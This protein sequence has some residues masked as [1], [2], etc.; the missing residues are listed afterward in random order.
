MIL[1]KDISGPSE[2]DVSIALNTD[3][4]TKKHKSK[5]LNISK[6]GKVKQMKMCNFVDGGYSTTSHHH[7]PSTAATFQQL[8]A[9]LDHYATNPVV[10][11]RIAS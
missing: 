2:F 4:T 7:Y 10:K 11:L 6:E 9:E 1:A 8:N 5:T 3:R